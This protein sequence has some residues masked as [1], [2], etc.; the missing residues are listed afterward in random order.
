MPGVYSAPALLNDWIKDLSAGSPVSTAGFRRWLASHPQKT[1]SVSRAMVDQALSRAVAA[2]DLVRVAPGLFVCQKKKAPLVWPLPEKALA[3]W[4][5]QTGEA[6]G[7]A[8]VAAAW[9]LDPALVS[10]GTRPAIWQVWTV[11][12]SRTL[13]LGPHVLE[14][15]H[16]APRWL[17]IEGKAGLALRYLKSLGQSGATPAVVNALLVSLPDTDR[18][19]L[20]ASPHLSGWMRERLVQ[21]GRPLWGLSRKE[22]AGV[23]RSARRNGQDVLGLVETW[24]RQAGSLVRPETWAN[25]WPSAWEMVLKE[26]N[27]DH[28]TVGPSGN[29]LLPAILSMLARAPLA[30][31]SR[32]REREIGNLWAGILR[33]WPD[34]GTL[35]A[36]IEKNPARLFLCR[37]LL[38]AWAIPES[39]ATLVMLD[40]KKGGSLFLRAGK[41][42]ISAWQD[43]MPAGVPFDSRLPVSIINALQGMLEESDL[44]TTLRTTPFDASEIVDFLE[45]A[46]RLPYSAR[47]LGPELLNPFLE[48]SAIVWDEAVDAL[49]E[50]ALDR[51]LHA[52]PVLGRLRLEHQ[53]VPSTLAP[54]PVR[55]RI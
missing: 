30:Q 34:T 14:F 52:F 37:G 6:W 45:A 5:D 20:L 48:N 31:Y 26:C 12:S 19:A 36:F 7:S 11:G 55:Q 4:G 1:S 41:N 3:A 23:L 29:P 35:Y 24:T 51:V 42:A 54:H 40:E 22:M 33:R 16:V 10:P 8:G 47:R 39:R 50:G 27:I 13:T 25:I 53:I 17:S 18:D 28:A 32:D 9:L 2:G 15:H 38:S 43:D 46:L 21:P 44:W 49:P